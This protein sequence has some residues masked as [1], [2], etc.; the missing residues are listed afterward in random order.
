[1]LEGPPRQ[2]EPPDRDPL[3]GFKW[4]FRNW[5]LIEETVFP[6][7]I[8]GGGI[9]PRKLRIPKWG[10]APGTGGVKGHARKHGGVGRIPSKP[11]A[12]YKD[13]FNHMR[14]GTKYRFYHDGQFKRGYVT[15][16]GN[17]RY[18][19]TS[20]SENGKTIFTHMEVSQQYL[21]NLGI[22]LKGG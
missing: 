4:A 12:Y 3:G 21:R 6:F 19:F 20:V 11:P 22:T 13:A 15:D 14:T 5:E 16:L 1:M 8:P 9:R 17:G 7:G 18:L 2:P 10:N